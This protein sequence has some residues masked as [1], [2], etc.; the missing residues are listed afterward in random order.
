MAIHCC[1]NCTPPKR[2]S[3]CHSKC[4]DYNRE[5]KVHE[6]EKSSI[7]RQQSAERAV[8]DVKFNN[9]NKKKGEKCK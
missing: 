8:F 1:K 2:H 6:A 3:G 4:S 9:Y 5:K 7:W